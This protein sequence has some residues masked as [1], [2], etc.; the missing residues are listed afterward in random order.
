[1]DIGALVSSAWNKYSKN[2]G[3]GMGIY[4]VGM[5]LGAALAGIVIGIPM[6]AGAYKGL[7]KIQRGETPDFSDV[8][9]EF[10]NLGQW[11]MLWVVMLVVGI[12][13]GI[14]AIIPVLGWLADAA[15]G[16]GLG[17]VLSMTIPL[18]LERRLAAFEAIKLSFDKVKTNFGTVFVALLV[19]YLI[20]AVSSV[21][22]VL[23]PLFVGPMVIIGVWEIYDTLFG[24][25]V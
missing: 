17:I 20:L 23:G 9:S 15:I 18:M 1:M 11:A 24:A 3:M 22:P 4:F 16:I 25:A 14:L 8:F 10:G 2:I 12:A 13:C 5:M 7:R 19:L 6:M 21:V